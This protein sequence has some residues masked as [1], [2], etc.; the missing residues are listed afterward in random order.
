MRTHGLGLAGLFW[1]STTSTRSESIATGAARVARGATISVATNPV[2]RIL[3]LYTMSKKP[4]GKLVCIELGRRIE[5][6]SDKKVTRHD[7]RHL[8]D[9]RA[10]CIDFGVLPP[11]PTQLGDSMMALHLRYC[12]PE[13][14][15]R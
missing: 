9:N 13:S 5:G 6:R 10:S 14:W 12:S 1:R 3:F 8:E 7:P 15:C 4:L 11:Y 2:R